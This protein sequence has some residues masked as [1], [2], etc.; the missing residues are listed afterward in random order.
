MTN[1]EE[2]QQDSIKFSIWDTN[3]EEVHLEQELTNRSEAF[4]KSLKNLGQASNL[5]DLK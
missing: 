5:N 2:F 1:K 3:T 4:N